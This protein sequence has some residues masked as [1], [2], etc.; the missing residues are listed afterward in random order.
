MGGMSPHGVDLDFDPDYNQRIMYKLED[1]MLTF[2]TLLIIMSRK[3]EALY[4]LER[5]IM[6]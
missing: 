4:C 3:E 5:C 6:I 2:N 1:L